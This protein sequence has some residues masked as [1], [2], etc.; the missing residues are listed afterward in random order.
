MPVKERE[1]LLDQ[2]GARRMVMGGFTSRN[3]GIFGRGWQEG[4]QSSPRFLHHNSQPSTC[5]QTDVPVEVIS[6]EDTFNSDGDSL[7]MTTIIRQGFHIEKL[8]V[9]RKSDHKC[10]LLYLMC[11]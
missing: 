7:T 9:K 8:R 3:V 4:I 2:R 11:L 5:R 1:F 10:E 6:N